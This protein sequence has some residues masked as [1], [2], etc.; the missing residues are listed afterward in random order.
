MRTSS[1]WTSVS[2]V[3]VENHLWISYD[4]YP[5]VD[6]FGACVLIFIGKGGQKAVQPT[7]VFSSSSHTNLI[8]I[9]YCCGWRCWRR[10]L[11]WWWINCLSWI[12]EDS[13]TWQMVYGLGPKNTITNIRI[14]KHHNIPIHR[15]TSKYYICSWM[16][17]EEKIG[18]ISVISSY[19][20]NLPLFTEFSTPNYDSYYVRDAIAINSA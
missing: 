12:V 4:F 13:V 2:F 17:S 15:H 20:F 19:K 10:W 7:Y 6:I 11:W 5:N 3:E 18:Q 9:C 16:F 1:E 8:P 14:Y